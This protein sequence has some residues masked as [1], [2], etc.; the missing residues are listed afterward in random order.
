MERENNIF[1]IAHKNDDFDRKPV[2]VMHI[3]T[4]VRDFLF[5]CSMAEVI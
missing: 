1:Y 4:R 3:Y 2:C 5:C